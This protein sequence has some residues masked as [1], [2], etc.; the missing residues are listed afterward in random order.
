MSDTCFKCHQPG[1]YAS[2]CPNSG[3]G[4]PAAGG[5]RSGGGGS[6]V[7]RNFVGNGYSGE[8]NFDYEQ[9]ERMLFPI[10]S[11]T[12]VHTKWMIKAR[13]VD[14]SEVRS[15]NNAR[16]EG[17][18][19]SC[20]LVDEAGTAIRATFFKEAVTKFYDLLQPN[21]VLYFGNAKVKA[22]SKKFS[23][24]PH[25]YEL[26]FSD[27]NIVQPV[28]SHDASQANLPTAVEACYIPLSEIVNHAV[29][30]SI[31]VIAVVKDPGMVSTIQKKAGG[32][33]QKRSIRIVDCSC[34][35]AFEMT[36]WA[37]QA[38]EFNGLEGTV[39]SAKNC[40]IGKFM[41]AINLVASNGVEIEPRGEQADRL[42]QWW[43]MCDKNSFENTQV[44]QRKVVTRWGLDQIEAQNM[45]R[46]EKSDILY[47]RG[48]I[49]AVSEKNVYY[50]ACPCPK[51]PTKPAD[52]DRNVCNKKV[53]EEGA[54]GM[55]WRCPTGMHGEI[56][57]PNYRYI[58]A[59]KF[60]DHTGNTYV[61]AFDKAAE[62]LFGMPAKDY[63][64]EMVKG[65]ENAS[66]VFK[67]LKEMVE[68]KPCTMTLRVKEESGG[69]QGPRVKAACLYSQV[70]KKAEDFYSDAAQ[71]RREIE[72]Y[73]QLQKF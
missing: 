47:V 17:I 26:T 67:A 30:N 45:G 57:Q 44:G 61:T 36:L 5:A 46:G 31:D 60:T 32:E 14:R 21:R 49:A 35:T 37:E 65:E 12:E 20:T 7:L 42:R 19:C 56:A 34:N 62:K 50:P 9:A 11:L 10:A 64:L 22:A 43:S 33:L 71:I 51:D 8:P 1:H 23:S 58:T 4:R 28:Q 55:Q 54:G 70:L 24:L 2:N 41:D 69:D 18:L 29:G 13:V 63:N 72:R 25:D 53:S 59:L 39:I 68:W 16:G 40:R 15:W 48:C 73:T 3:G 66:K 52:D 6:E 38:C 27:D